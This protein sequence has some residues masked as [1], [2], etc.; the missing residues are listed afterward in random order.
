MG[1]RAKGQLS[2]TLEKQRAKLEAELIRSLAPR[3]PAP[4]DSALTPEQLE[5]ARRRALEDSLKKAA[6]GLLEGFLKPS[7]PDTT[8]R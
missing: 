3:T 7:K 4:G 2:S 6:R 5:R 8:K 1:E